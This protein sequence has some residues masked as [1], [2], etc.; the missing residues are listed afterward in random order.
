MAKSSARWLHNP[1]R[2]GGP[3]RFRVGYRIRSGPQ[4]GHVATLPLSLGR[5]PTLHTGEQNQKWR[6]S[7]PGGYITRAAWEVPN[8]S[9]RG[10]ASAVGN[11]WAV[12]LHNPCRLRVN[13]RVTTG[14]RTKRGPQVG[15]VATQPLLHG[16]SPMLQSG[17]QNR[18]LSTSGARWLHNPHRQGG[19]QHFTARDRIRSG[20]Q[21]GHVATSPLPLEGYQTLH[22]GGQNKQWTTSGPRGYMTTAT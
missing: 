16:G 2:M 14:D 19:T 17:G 20:Q 5:S 6:T 22:S 3:Q 10:I 7:W 21:L 12:W 1:C 11:K 9:K 15:H 8:S 13:Q 18:K 4:V